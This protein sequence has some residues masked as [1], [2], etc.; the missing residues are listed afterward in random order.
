MEISSLIYGPTLARPQLATCTT[1][2]EATPLQLWRMTLTLRLPNAGPAGWGHGELIT[3]WVNPDATI[4][5]TESV[6]LP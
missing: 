5:H 6:S 1:A 2:I 3:V 4:E